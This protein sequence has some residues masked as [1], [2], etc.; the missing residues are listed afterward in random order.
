M[1]YCYFS[2]LLPVCSV[3][4]SADLLCRAPASARYIQVLRVCCVSA[5]SISG[6]PELDGTA[7]LLE[8]YID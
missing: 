5:P 2:A 6:S 7:D 3:Q 1:L 4:N 8:I